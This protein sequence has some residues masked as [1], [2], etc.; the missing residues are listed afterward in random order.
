MNKPFAS[1]TTVS[2]RYIVNDVDSCVAFYTEILGFDVTMKA[3]GFAMLTNGNLRLLINK[4][5][6][7]GAGQNMPD[8]VVPAPGG[9]NRFQLEVK[10]IESVINDLKGKRVHFRNEL[11]KANAGNQILVVDPSGN[12]IELFEPK[13]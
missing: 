3:P 13:A 9:W 8:G 12:L 11:V 7:G 5:G 6:A 4:P 2:V 10:D 1:P